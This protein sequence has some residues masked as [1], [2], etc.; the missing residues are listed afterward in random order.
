M[1]FGENEKKIEIPGF[2]ITGNIIK[3]ENTMVQLRNVSY[4]TTGELPKKPIPLIGL[5]IGVVWL[6]LWNMENDN[7]K[8]H[9]T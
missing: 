1:K 5:A 3:W 8:K 9:K 7:R 4:I 2:T 6:Y